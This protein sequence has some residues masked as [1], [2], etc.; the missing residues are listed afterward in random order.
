MLYI[1]KTSQRNE[2]V[3]MNVQL[4]KNAFGHPT[5]MIKNK[6]ESVS[7]FLGID[8]NADRKNP[9]KNSIL[10]VTCK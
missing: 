2:S 3:F 9:E 1:K 7:W 6:N 10:L 4:N 8:L 5:W